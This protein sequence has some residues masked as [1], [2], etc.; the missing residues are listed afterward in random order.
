MNWTELNL[1]QLDDAMIEVGFEPIRHLEYEDHSGSTIKLNPSFE[2]PGT[3]GIWCLAIEV[4][5]P[6]SAFA[7]VVA[8]SRQLTREQTADL[9]EC[10][11]EHHTYRR[12]GDTTATYYFRHFVLEEI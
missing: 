10:A 8:A 7:F 1:A 5:D 9:A 3:G 4:T 12:V 11:R 2:M 6:A